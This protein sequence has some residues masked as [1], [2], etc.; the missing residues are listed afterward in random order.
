M[1]DRP[2]RHPPPRGATIRDLLA[3]ELRGGW[4]SAR[5]LSSLV[6]ISEK[7]VPEH[8]EHLR[9]SAASGDGEFEIEPAVCS[10]CDHVF[11]DRTRLTRPSRCPEC[12]GQR[13]EPPRFRIV[14]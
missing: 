14:E 12:K 9:K 8:L 10:R 11:D 1:T 2:A 6:G 3:A 5:Q 7:T 13:I 4:V